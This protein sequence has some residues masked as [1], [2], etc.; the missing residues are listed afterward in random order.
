MNCNKKKRREILTY[1]NKFKYLGDDTERHANYI[2]SVIM[3]LVAF[4]LTLFLIGIGAYDRGGQ[5]IKVGD[6][7]MELYVAPRDVVD[8]VATD[9]LKEAAASSVVPMYKN[10]STVEDRTIN[11]VSELFKD[12]NDIANNNR[13]VYDG[14]NNE[15]YEGEGVGDNPMSRTQENDNVYPQEMIIKNE[16]VLALPV[17]F[18]EK[19]LDTYMALT[20]N[21]RKNMEN[22]TIDALVNAYSDGITAEGLELAKADTYTALQQ[23]TRDVEIRNMAYTI[24]SSALE[25]NL[26]LDEEVMEYER[27]I[28]RN[29]VADVL[30]RKNQKIV[31]EGEII[32]QDIYDKLVALGIINN[33]IASG[34]N[35][36]L[37]SIY[38]LFGNVVITSLL[39]GFACI[40]LRGSKNTS[41]GE[42]QLNEQKMLF[43]I[44]LG[45]IFVMRAMAGSVYFTLIPL[46]LFSMLVSA[47]LGRRIALVFHACCCMIGCVIFAGDVEFLMYSFI[48]GF[49]GA[50]LIKNTQKRSQT[51][52]VALGMMI[53]NFMAVLGIG[54]FF[55]EAY[56]KD[57]FIMAGLGGLTGLISVIV[58]LGSLPFWEEVFEANTPL[59]LLEFTNP[60]HELL[61][62]MMIEAPATYHHSLLVANL[63]E[64]AT[65]AIGGNIALA[66]AGA[67]YHDVGKLKSPMHFAENQTGYNPHDDLA[68]EESASIITNHTTDGYAMG[69]DYK[70]PK[71]ILNIMVE[72][73]GTSTVKYF[74]YKAL[75]EGNRDDVKEED[76]RYKGN[77][78]QSRESAIIMLADTAEAAV[79]AKLGQGGNL[80][81]ADEFLKGLIK[82][83]LD[84]G[85]LVDSK[86]MIH[87]LDIIRNA[88][89]EVFHGMY[90]ERVV[91]PDKAEMDKLKQGKT[92]N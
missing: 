28:K 4:V 91:Y 11:L 41:K 57:L 18:T 75:K 44:Y 53:V 55:R 32:D 73:H 5:I 92:G 81:E 8:Q 31:G 40:F 34:D 59:Y 54:L 50:V 58:T 26:I 84:D 78:P 66:R 12:L 68:P 45:M 89:M 85:Q 21:E 71:Q 43:W 52:Y 47:L 51:V 82:D 48:S 86:L 38:V 74:Y 69:E 2:Q 36:T 17:V 20:T 27:E 25:P 49:F 61:R 60:N 62:R 19:Q 13:V 42:L 7:S 6:I 33:N 35:H 90:H 80:A 39:F 76:Y 24:M 87:E 29:E 83:K 15:I 67:Y 37:E 30:I 79:R 46:E 88:F 22:S 14:I 56:S 10:D 63:A 1:K 64:T 77:V 65:Y 3:F 72:H 9:K 70:L 23:E 16:L